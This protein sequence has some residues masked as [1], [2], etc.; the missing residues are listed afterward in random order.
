MDPIP[1]R[2]ALSTRRAA[3]VDEWFAETLKTYPAETSRFFGTE[4]DRFRNP[5]GHALRENLAALFDAVML[6]D[7]WDQAARAL[8]ELVQL[9]AVQD[10]TEAEAIGFIEPLKGILRQATTGLKPCSTAQG[11]VARDFSPAF[12]NDLLSL[13]DARVDR[14]MLLA[15]DLYEKCRA[16]MAGI[17]VNEAKRRT[18]L[19]DRVHRRQV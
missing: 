6:S 11:H 15:A 10:F 4:A 3:L 13:L 17:R 19:L 1:L 14:L 2:D 5:A 18:W 9:R 12:P 7:D 8:G 16:R